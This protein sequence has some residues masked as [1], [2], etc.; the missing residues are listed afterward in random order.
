MYCT[1]LSL[2]LNLRNMHVA[3]HDLLPCQSILPG[4]PQ[5]IDHMASRKIKVIIPLDPDDARANGLSPRN[6]KKT[7]RSHHTHHKRSQLMS[8]ACTA[9]HVLGDNDIVQ[10]CRKDKIRY[11]SRKIDTGDLHVYLSKDLFIH[12]FTPPKP[13][14]GSRP[15]RTLPN[16]ANREMWRRERKATKRPILSSPSRL[17]GPQTRV[18]VPLFPSTL[19]MLPPSSCHQDTYTQK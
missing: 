9:R 8:H 15:T 3:V 4:L 14:Q 12:Y 2:L 1:W 19:D 6:T 7:Q 5:A 13:H 11:K 10:M 16:D 17:Q 18:S